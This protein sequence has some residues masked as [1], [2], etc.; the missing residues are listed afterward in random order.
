VKKLL[1][2][3]SLYLLISSS[4]AR[5]VP[6]M[7]GPVV[8]EA[9]LLS[10]EV[11]IAIENALIELNQSQGIQFQVLFIDTLDGDPIENFSIKVVDEWKLG[12]KGEDKAALFLMAIKE[13]KLRIEV[14]RGLEGDL[15][16]LATRR[17]ISDLRPY[18]KSG[19]YDNG[20]LLALTLMA[21]SAKTELQFKGNFNSRPVRQKSI[22]GAI[23]LI[24]LIGFILFV[25]FFF[26][27]GG[28]FGGGGFYGGGGFGG[29]GFGGGSSGGDWGGGGGGFS[30]GG[31]S[32]D[33]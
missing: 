16:D 31:S 29:G 28:G 10:P 22:P 9:G 3:Y 25:R 18:F 32:G 27:G 2:F 5:T 6:P 14:G 23:I 1:I 12:K 21:K 33:F 11:K 8:D 20:T 17:I 13:R 4:F 19:E 26:P 30:G 15:T 7:T 24:V